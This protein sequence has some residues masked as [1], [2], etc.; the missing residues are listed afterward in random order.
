MFA[1]AKK[2]W[3]H[4]LVNIRAISS[5]GLERLVYTQEVGGS[6]P[7]SPTKG[8]QCNVESLFLYLYFGEIEKIK[9]RYFYSS[10][11]LPF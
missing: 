10:L 5:V 8:F 9:M 11:S 1:L 6:N 4:S 2:G 7:S 3:Q